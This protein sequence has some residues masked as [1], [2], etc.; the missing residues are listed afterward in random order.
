ML[1]KSF[2]F[3]NSDTFASSFVRS[4]NVLIIIVFIVFALVIDLVTI[5]GGLNTRESGIFCFVCFVLG[6][7][8]VCVSGLGIVSS[9]SGGESVGYTGAVGGCCIVAF[10]ILLGFSGSCRVLALCLM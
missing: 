2:S 7:D 6:V 1:L 3:A 10:G 5:P 9:S 4:V 8:T